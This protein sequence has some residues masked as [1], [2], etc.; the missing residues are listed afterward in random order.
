MEE[1]LCVLRMIGQYHLPNNVFRMVKG[2]SKH[3]AYHRMTHQ[4]NR[5]AQLLPFEMR[6]G[7]FDSPFSI[8]H[9]VCITGLSVGA[10]RALVRCVKRRSS[11]SSLVISEHGETARRPHREDMRISSYVFYEP[12]AEYYDCLWFIL[13]GVCAN[14]E[15]RFG[16]TSQPVFVELRSLRVRHLL[17]TKMS[18][19]ND[20]IMFPFHLDVFTSQLPSRWVGVCEA[21]GEDEMIMVDGK[22]HNRHL[23][24]I[25]SLDHCARITCKRSCGR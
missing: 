23:R 6:M 1:L 14:V 15:F 9:L 10:I 4:V 19:S 3:S 8:S 13:R 12:M 5:N 24:F 7:R 17:E 11:K 21:D 16:W 25:P 18:R 20:I 22:W 2:L